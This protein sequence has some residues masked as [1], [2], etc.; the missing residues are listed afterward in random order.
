MSADFSGR[1]TAFYDFTNGGTVAR[2]PYDDYG[3]GTHVA[4]TIA[5]SGA[6]SSNRDKR[7]LAPD[8]KLVVLKVLDKD[9]AGYTSD[10]IRAIDFAVENRSRFDID[11]VNLSLGHPIFEPAATDPL[12]Q[13]VERA[14]RAGLIV[15]TAAGNFGKNPDTGLTGYAGITSPGNAPSAITVGAVRTEDTVTRTDDRIADY[16]SA[17]PTWYDAYVKPDI[18]SP[19]HNIIAAAARQGTL[20]NAYPQLKDADPDYMRLSGTSMATAVTSGSVALLIEANRAANAGHPPLTPNAV[21]AILHYTAVG[22]QSASGIEYDPLRKGAGSINPKG[23]IDLANRIDTSRSTGQWWLASMPYPWTTIGTETYTWNQAIV[24]GNAIVWGS[25]VG[26]NETAWGSAIVWGSTTTW[27]S[28]IVWGSNVVWT[29]SQS[30][31]NAIVW[32]SDSIGESNGTAIVW[33]SSGPTAEST[34]WKD[35][36]GSGME[37][38]GQ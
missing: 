32:G 26:V 34:A 20:Y 25:T 28:A 22:I 7:G 31:G 5:G 19:G 33:G 6:R 21:K 1:V 18:V 11:I 16:S 14:S 17:G 2:Y 10:V 3:H 27:G 37:A 38:N 29:D 24:W 30:W 36:D 4:G 9:G 35:L 8:V 15:V 23:A 13:A 12:V